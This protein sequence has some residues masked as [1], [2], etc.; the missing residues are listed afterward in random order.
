MSFS[1]TNI[2]YVLRWIALWLNNTNWLLFDILSI[3]CAY[4]KLCDLNIIWIE[5]NIYYFI[6]VHLNTE[7]FVSGTSKKRNNGSSVWI[8]HYEECAELLF[9]THFINV[10]LIITL[11]R[12]KKEIDR[13]GGKVDIFCL[14]SELWCDKIDPNS[15]KE[16]PCRK[17]QSP[18]LWLIWSFRSLFWLSPLFARQ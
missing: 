5:D 7:Y 6:V 8:T 11:A 14:F 13:V 9:V 10:K 2:L 16:K 4:R 3:A 12:A 1:E 15:K 17:V 18:V